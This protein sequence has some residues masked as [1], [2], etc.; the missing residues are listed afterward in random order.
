MGIDLTELKRLREETSAPVSACKEALDEAGGNYDKARELIKKR[1]QEVVDKK[2]SRETKEGLLGSYVH[3]NGKM[4]AMV[5]VLCETDFV[6]KN[7]EFIA[8]VHDVALQVAAT[9]PMFVSIDDV[10]DEA[11]ADEKARIEEEVAKEDKP[12]EVKA[13]I[14]EGKLN[15]FKTEISLMSLPLVK[16]ADKTLGEALADITGKLGEKI[17]IGEFVRFEI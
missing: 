12:E 1:G 13:K 5:K 4:G 2:S 11:L 6:A 8:F 16:D 7:E 14:I 17:E 3:S 9:N 10:T 15:K